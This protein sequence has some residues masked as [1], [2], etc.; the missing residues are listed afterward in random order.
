[1]TSTLCIFFSNEV[2]KPCNL[3]YPSLSIRLL[4]LFK[5]EEPHRSGITNKEYH[6]EEVIEIDCQLSI[7]TFFYTITVGAVVLDK[8]S[9]LVAS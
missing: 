2:F 9:L 6:Y 3:S 4:Q 1:M 7:Y 5:P 8:I